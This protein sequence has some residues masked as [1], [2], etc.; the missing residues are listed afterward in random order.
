MTY[1]RARLWTG[2]SCVGMLVV[3]SLAAWLWQVPA[4]LFPYD[5]GPLWT[6]WAAFVTLYF[7]YTVLMLPFDVV[8]GFLLPCRHHRLCIPFPLFLMRWVRGVT[9]QGLVM[10]LSGL[11]LFEA[12]RAR[13]LWAAAGM[14]VLL[15]F[16]LISFQLF[17]ARLAGGLGI[18]R[19]SA[20]T[21]ALRIAEM[22]GLD[23]GFTGGI[24][25]LPGV[26]TVV[27]P[28]FWRKHLP[29]RAFQAE[30]LHR[31][32]ALRSGARIRGMALAM[33]WNL[34][35]FV[36]CAHL[37]GAGVERLWEFVS[38]LLAFT[39]WSFLG[40]LLLPS[41]N[42]RS[43]FQADRYAAGHGA[44][45]GDIRQLLT[46]LDQWQDE[47]PSRHPWVERVFHPIPSV[48]NRLLQLSDGLGGGG[49]WHGARLALYLSWANFGLLSRAVHC[50]AG[51]PERWVML[52]AD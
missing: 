21:G 9:V 10:T 15:Q 46:A 30:I 1:A 37:P 17:M 18:A 40:L 38:T 48:E 14:L 29:E 45:M 12:G 43:V 26:E 35:G 51:M 13:G 11:L 7:I 49:A 47:E 19:R 44:I 39:L 22:H 34:A 20:E 2:A 4:T 5:G 33:L 28:D 8:A 41:L 24:S 42:R 36:I 31:T 50:N 52:P 23:S 16:A 27:L 32:G 25:G 6:E 3:L